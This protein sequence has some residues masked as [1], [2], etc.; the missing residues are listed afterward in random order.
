MPTIAD[1]AIFDKH[2]DILE[3]TIGLNN[4]ESCLAD[5][6][7]S[8][9]NEVDWLNKI[10]PSD[11]HLILIGHLESILQGKSNWNKKDAKVFR[12]SLR[13]LLKSTKGML[14]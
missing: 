14:C 9:S 2:M 6:I 13:A 3:N 1:C 12:R 4:L 11:Q 7:A 5:Q 8:L 10:E